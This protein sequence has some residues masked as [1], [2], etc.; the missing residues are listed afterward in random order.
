MVPL[1][2]FLSPRLS[3]VGDRSLSLGTRLLAFF[4]YIYCHGSI[5]FLIVHYGRYYASTPRVVIERDIRLPSKVESNFIKEL[6][7]SSY[8]YLILFFIEYL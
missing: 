6:I 7:S 8:V 5:S 1:S 2:F 3:W 4:S